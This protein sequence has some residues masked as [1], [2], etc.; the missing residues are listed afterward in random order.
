ME[1]SSQLRSPIALFPVPVGKQMGRPKSH[2]DE[3]VNT[4]ITPLPVVYYIYLTML[5]VAQATWRGMIGLSVN[6]E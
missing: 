1:V 6:N 4:L 3:V 2:L 5:S